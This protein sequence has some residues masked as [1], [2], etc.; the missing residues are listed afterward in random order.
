MRGGQGWS[1]VEA[2][3]DALEADKS[4]A[5]YAKYK[6]NKQRDNVGS[7]AECIDGARHVDAFRA[8][9]VNE[10]REGAA[11]SL[12]IY[13][14]IPFRSRAGRRCPVYLSSGVW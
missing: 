8:F 4:A 12:F 11:L 13:Q 14:A 7:C 2:R 5:K 6:Q 10:K 1:N 9:G 3:V